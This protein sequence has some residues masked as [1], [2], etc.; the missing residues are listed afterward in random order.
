MGHLTDSGSGATH[1]FRKGSGVQLTDFGYG[2]RGL[3]LG[4][5]TGQYIEPR[6]FVGVFCGFREVGSVF[7]AQE[8]EGEGR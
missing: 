4:F 6:G 1:A 5:R 8:R 3:H 2:F 7:M